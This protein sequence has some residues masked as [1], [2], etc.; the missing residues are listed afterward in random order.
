MKRLLVLF[1][2]ISVLSFPQR[3]H[4]M[5]KEFVTSCT[6]GVIAGTIVGAATLA[7]SQNPGDK[8]HRISRGASLGLYAGIMLGFYVTYGVGGG[9]EYDEEGDPYVW[10]KKVQPPDLVVFP[11][12]SQN[13][14][15]GAAATWNVYH[16]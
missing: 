6:Y 13:G 2:L 11:L 8:L 1:G 9:D 15:D 7:F 4:S 10:K 16:F 12:L 3:S 14:L 5:G